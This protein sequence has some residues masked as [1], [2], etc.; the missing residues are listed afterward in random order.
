MAAIRHMYEL[1]WL[2]VREVDDIT[3]LPVFK[4]GTQQIERV[5]DIHGLTSGPVAQC[6][7]ERKPRNAPCD[8][9]SSCTELSRSTGRCDVSDT[10]CF[11]AN[12]SR[13]YWAATPR[14][15]VLISARALLIVSSA[16]PHRMVEHH[17]FSLT[18]G[19]VARACSR[20]FRAA[21]LVG[22]GGRLRCSRR[23]S[24]TT[25]CVWTR[26]GMR[27]VRSR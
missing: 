18:S 11:G 8:T 1:P 27:R 21:P 12:R 2:A 10:R 25:M 19:N 24:S 6:S 14:S 16:A 3:L 7:I 17:E 5:T 13:K 4:C 26:P 23:S 20:D 22:G 15:V 9:P